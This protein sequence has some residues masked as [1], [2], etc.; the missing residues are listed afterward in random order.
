MV[1]EAIME[2]VVGTALMTT[3]M[4]VL[5]YFAGDH[6]KVVKVL[7]TMLTFKI[8]DNRWLS[9]ATIAIIV[10]VAAHYLVGIGFAFVYQWLW[11]SDKLDASILNATWMGFLNGV[12]GA[13]GW[14]IFFAIH[15]KPPLIPLPIYLTAITFG[16][17]FFAYGILSAYLLLTGIL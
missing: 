5:A 1:V 13:I 14:R 3:V 17:I 10:G 7:G 2:G 6:F 9:N 8:T 15:P 16:H 4:Y 12:V 11:S